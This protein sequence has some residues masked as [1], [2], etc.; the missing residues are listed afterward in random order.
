MEDNKL[1]NFDIYQKLI[2][3]SQKIYS[4]FIKEPYIN[5]NIYPLFNISTLSEY[6][7]VNITFIHKFHKYFLDYPKFADLIVEN[8]LQTTAS[9][10]DIMLSVLHMSTYVELVSVLEN[11]VHVI[12]EETGKNQQGNRE[13]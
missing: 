10:S 7:T 5:F 12:A 11:L 6:I 1:T 13:Q 4:D 8:L 3:K 9:L 2:Y